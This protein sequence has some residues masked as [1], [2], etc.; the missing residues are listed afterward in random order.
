MGSGET[1]LETIV[2]VILIVG[3][4]SSVFLE[5]VG[6]ALYFSAHGDVLISQDPSVFIHGEN[7]FAFTILQIQSL[8]AAQTALVFMALGI[9]VLILTPYIRALTSVLYFGWEKNRKYVYIT[10]FVLVVLTISLALH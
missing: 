2:S 7:F 4:V 10:L 6:M 8:L 3:V 1:T 5:I 9:I